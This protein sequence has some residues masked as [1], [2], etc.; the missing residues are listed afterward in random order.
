MVRTSHITN[1]SN[2]I[3]KLL[4]EPSIKSFISSHETVEGRKI[5]KECIDILSIYPMSNGESTYFR[6]KWQVL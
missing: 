6:V 5:K 2:S 3:P 1:L 4:I